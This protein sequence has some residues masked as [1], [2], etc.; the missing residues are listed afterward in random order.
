[1]TQD[2]WTAVDTYLAGLFVPPDPALDGVLQSIAAADLPTISV[3]PNQGKLLFI[4]AKAMGARRV[5][6][7]GTLAGYSTIWL[8]RA[9]PPG[10][11]VVT[12]EVDPRHAKIARA[13]IARAGMADRIDLRVGAALEVLPGLA[14]GNAGPFD[15]IF[16]DADKVGYPDYLSWAIKLA[17]PG[18]LILADNVIRDG[19]V[20]DPASKDASVLAVRRFNEMLANEPRVIATAIQTV[21]AKGYDGFAAFLVT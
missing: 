19:A 11:S 13:N 12:I 7:L 17:R 4:L 21:G 15:L 10:G 3:S 6:E 2:R 9:V 5:L 18:A 8:A 16:I 20:A 1:V 14:A